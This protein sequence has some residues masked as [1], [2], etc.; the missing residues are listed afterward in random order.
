MHDVRILNGI[1]V[2]D[3]TTRRLDV[4][5]EDRHIVELEEPG[6]LG[7]GRFELDASGLHVLPGAIDVHFHCRSPSHPERGDFASETTAAAAGG[8]TTVFEMPVSDPAC[9]T[10]EVFRSRRAL[11]SAHAHVNV[12]LY[13]GG[14]LTSARHAAEM[15]E[16]GAIGF[17]LFTIEPVPERAREFA[18][19]WATD[20]GRILEAFEAVRPTGLPMVVHAENERLVRYYAQRNS[21]DVR[22]SRPPVIEAAAIAAV[23]TLAKEADIH[24]HVAHVS[25]RAALETVAAGRK[26]GAR[27]SAETCPQYL[28]LD[29]SAVT[30]H[31]SVAKIAPPLRQRTDVNA[32]WDGLA[33][34]QLSVVA[35]D[36]A[37][38]LVHEKLTTWA[39]APQGLPTVE[40]LVPVIL[41]GVVRGRLP[42]ADA[43]AA[44]TSTP[45]R[46]FGIYPRKGVIAVGSDADIALVALGQEFRPT[47]ETLR[48]RAAGCAVV[49]AGLNLL[50]RVEHTFVNGALAYSCNTISS[51]VQGL[52]VPGPAVAREANVVV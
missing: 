41:D 27:I 10:P 42:L 24:L 43:V 3:G 6:A 47:P 22:Q 20:E 33:T 4:G 36:H 8:V 40:L 39:Q 30:T 45:A 51:A 32:L 15:A 23:A 52:F 14:A 29:A 16:L 1:V 34:G 31:G 12:G 17:K 5:I 19:L 38:F 25:S 26:L 35:S 44:I 46:L 28:A 37:P 2:S 7:P 9:S 11:A 18:G 50:A 49:F 21:S 48:T 13:S